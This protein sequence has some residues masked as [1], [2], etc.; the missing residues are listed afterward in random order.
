MQCYKYYKYIIFFSIS[1][2]LG[3]V[4]RNK[5]NEQFNIGAFIFVYSERR[6]LM[7]TTRVLEYFALYNA[8]DG[9]NCPSNLK[10][11]LIAGKVIVYQIIIADF[12]PH[13]NFIDSVFHMLA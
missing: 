8:I 2:K 4:K 6:K 11:Q 13:T 5:M 10:I 1:L 3:L 7:Y 12:L 9:T